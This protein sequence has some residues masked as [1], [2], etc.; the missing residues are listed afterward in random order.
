MQVANNR[1]RMCARNYYGA[2]FIAPS[3]GPIMGASPDPG[4]TGDW[5]GE[6]RGSVNQVHTYSQSH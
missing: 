1:S 6:L 4:P 2:Q 3:K 5:G